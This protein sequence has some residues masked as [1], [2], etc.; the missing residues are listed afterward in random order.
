MSFVSFFLK[1]QLQHFFKPKLRI[2]KLA[3]NSARNTIEGK[4]G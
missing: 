3:E 2:Q 4:L 1:N